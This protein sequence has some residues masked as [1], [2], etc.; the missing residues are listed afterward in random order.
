MRVIISRII[1]TF[2]LLASLVAGLLIPADT[3]QAGAHEIMVTSHG[4][5]SQFPDGVRFFIQASG[6][7]EIVDIRVT[8]KKIGQTSRSSYRTLEFSQG[9]SIEGE[10]LMRSGS[11]GEYIP[12]G[13]RIEYSFQIQDSTGRELR[14]EPQVFIYLDTRFDWGTVT[15]GLITVFYQG[16]GMADR[17]QV[18]L[19]VAGQTLDRMRPVLGIDPKVPLHILTYENYRD[20]RVALPLRSR[21]TSEQLITQGMAFKE[22][23][24]LLV[25]GQGNSYVGTTSHEFTHLLVADA[26]GR[27]IGR[28]PAWLNEGLAE[29][30][31]VEDSGEYDRYLQRAIAEGKLRPLWHLGTFSG[32]PSEI[33]LSYGQGESV[34]E[35]LIA[36]YGEAQM[37]ELI[38]GIKRTFDIDKALDQAYGLDLYGLDSEWRQSLGV[39]PLQPPETRQPRVR[40]TREP[41]PLPTAT[42]LTTETPTNAPVATTAPPAEP[43]SSSE[44]IPGAT[45]AANGER[46][47]AAPGCGAATQQAGMVADLAML[48]LMG[49][50]LGLLGLGVLRRRRR[51]SLYRPPE[52]PRV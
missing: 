9:K 4:A 23:R 34:V 39:E 45:P 36:T 26:T 21:A 50:P 49:G 35:Y 5:E 40:A 7:D 14:T 18:M 16:E 52:K 15:D 13:T 51:D 30:G 19:E 10:T 3:V 12:P 32:S 43:K 6:P 25:L 41:S 8:F 31:N 17:A 47:T 22:E 27:A 48:S 1:L 46:T 44:S 28:V 37:V 42:A 24:V 20:M 38:R 33:I 29:Y 2:I 11:G